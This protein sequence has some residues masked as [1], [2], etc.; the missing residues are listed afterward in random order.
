MASVFTDER[1]IGKK[2]VAT[3]ASP[4]NLEKARSTDLE[5][6]NPTSRHNKHLLV[7]PWLDSECA[8]IENCVF[9]H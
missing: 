2:A 8:G 3:R 9:T 5:E 6:T 7:F 4:K 1:H